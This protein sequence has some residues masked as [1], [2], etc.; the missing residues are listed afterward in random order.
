MNIWENP[1]AVKFVFYSESWSWLASISQY[2]HLFLTGH[3]L[4]FMLLQCYFGPQK[5][6]PES[7]MTLP[8]AQ[9]PW[10][11]NNTLKSVK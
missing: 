10:T 2:H 8:V 11:S 1:C 7:T 4:S 9:L 5:Y 6:I 3:Y